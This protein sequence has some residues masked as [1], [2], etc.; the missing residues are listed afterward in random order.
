MSSRIMHRQEIPK[1]PPQERIHNFKEVALGY[2]EERA[3]AE[4][5]RCLQCPN[6]PCV[7]GCPV[8]IDIP[9]FIK[10]IAERDFAA[11]AE[12]L[13]EKNSLP[14]VCGR[15]C[16]QEEQCEKSCTLAHKSQPIAIGCLERFVAD[17][18][19]SK[20]PV[21][22][23]QYAVGKMKDKRSKI[24]NCQLSVVN[25]SQPSVAVIGSGPAGLTVAGELA[26]LGYSVVIFEAL[27]LPGGV[28]TYGIPEFRLPKEIVKEEVR[29][30]QS[31]SVEIKTDYVIGKIETIDGLFKRGFKAV[32]VAI[33]AG[34]PK[35]MGI[36][37]ENLIDVYSANEFLTR[38]NLMKAYLFPRVATPIKIGR[39]V[40]VI[41]GGN[42]ALDSARTAIRLGAEE[43]YVLYRRS[44]E[45]M[46][47]RAEEFE[48]AREEGIKFKFLTQ[49]I[50]IIGGKRR[51]VRAMECL[52][53]KLGEPDTSGRHRPIPIVGSNFVIELNTVI[54][55]I[56]T[57]ANP[58]LPGSVPDLEVNKKGYIKVDAEGR[59]SKKG[60]FAGGDIVGGSATVI[61]AMGMAKRAAL[62][63]DRYIR[64]LRSE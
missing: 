26:K 57:G 40:G 44:A 20:S 6:K 46:P 37:G 55:A 16:P 21:S 56:G 63:I 13:R 47:A 24:A 2:D 53:M 12:I 64:S 4:A 62:A 27:H 50:R 29:Y 45:E 38:V 43:V 54:I 31:L 59:T 60:V 23:M 42:V 28:L 52:R 25:Y 3:V 11:A 33:G 1:Q 35:F 18:E 49:P 32:Y 5:K 51:N 36:D 7:R 19:I 30:L 39:R 17:W 22:S 8:G 14:A 9:A 61:A 34:L 41:G 15:V 48:N 58:L 10:K